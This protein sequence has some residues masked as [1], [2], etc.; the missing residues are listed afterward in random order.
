MRTVLG[1]AIVAALGTAGCSRDEIPVKKGKGI[2]DY[3]HG[4][5]EAAIAAFVKAKR[6]PEAYDKMFRTVLVLRPGMDRATAEEAERSMM[7]LALAP[8]EEV[9]KRPM[10]EQVSTLALTVWPAILTDRL[11]ADEI[12]HKRDPK[13]DDILPK[14]GETPT[15]YLQRICGEQ[16]ASECKHAVPELQGHV[17]DALVVRRALERAR[18]AVADCLT[19]SVD[20]GWQKAVDGWEKLDHEVNKW[21]HDVDDRADPANWP[22]AGAASQPDPGLPEAE[23][24]NSGEV[25]I[26]GQRYGAN[27]RLDALRDLRFM[28]GA[29]SPV[30]LHLH[31]DL[32]LAKVR[33]ILFDVRK[34]GVKK[35]A[36]IAR[37]TYYPWERRVY[38]LSDVTGRRTN[39]RPTDSLQL[40]LHAMD[41]VGQPGETVLVDK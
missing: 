11:E 21:I 28:H 31:P 39:L 23:F 16:L 8:V 14:A 40:L 17:V 34:S 35:I 15:G 36:V 9:S 20:P 10:K 37:G 4:K 12:L 18:N 6:T 33:A 29:D 41:Y 3:N 26:G 32:E 5:L 38:W 27:T 2:A 22:I 30:A 19:C 25:I 13:I 7:T 24:T 1:F